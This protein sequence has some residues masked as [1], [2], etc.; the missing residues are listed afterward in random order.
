MIKQMRNIAWLA[1]V[2]AVFHQCGVGPVGDT[3]GASE[4]VAIVIN[5]LTITGETKKKTEDNIEQSN[6]DVLLQIYDNDFLPYPYFLNSLNNI[7]K[8]TVS[9]SSGVFQ[10]TDMREGIYNLLGKDV[11]SGKSV[12]ISN[13][14]VGSGINDTIAG[15]FSYP[16]SIGGSVRIITATSDTVAAVGYDVFIP[17]TPFKTAADSGGA[18]QLDTLPRGEYFILSTSISGLMDTAWTDHP[19]SLI[20]MIIGME[21]D[22]VPLESDEI[23]SDLDIILQK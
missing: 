23:I 5:G 11:A 22:T 17:G 19:D 7:T 1:C 21:G 13:I 14:K 8:S 10:F 16:G 18:F 9:D 20:G 3:G 15:M 6:P 12:F 4:T 2:G